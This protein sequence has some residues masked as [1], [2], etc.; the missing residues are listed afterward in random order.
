MDPFKKGYFE[1]P[2]FKGSL[3]LK[4]VLPVM[5]PDLSYAELDIS[6]GGSAAASWVRMVSGNLSEKEKTEIY[7]NLLKY[8]E[9]DTLAMVKIF[10][11]LESFI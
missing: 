9:L 6:E 8:C 7:E 5:A 4:K 2:G 11:K 10:E 3:S 1:H